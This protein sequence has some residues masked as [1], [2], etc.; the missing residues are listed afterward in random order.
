[1]AV[2]EKGRPTPVTRQ[3]LIR[4][5]MGIGLGLII[6]LAF[7]IT[8]WARRPSPASA[9]GALPTATTIVLGDACPTSITLP[10]WTQKVGVT[11]LTLAQGGVGYFGNGLHE[12]AEWYPQSRWTLY[13][14][15]LSA[16]DVAIDQE[17]LNT[18]PRLP[19]SGR[20]SLHAG[21]KHWVMTAAWRAS[22]CL[23]F[24]APVQSLSEIP[25]LLD[26]V[27]MRR[28]HPGLRVRCTLH[29]TSAGTF[30]GACQITGSAP[31]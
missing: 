17:V 11:T 26:I 31:S 10:A 21:A 19:D 7:L 16:T 8:L 5:A 25:A 27:K 24:S 28:V 13:L 3:S 12:E 22:D 20:V 2:L 30:F 15:G 9:K 29:L 14:G 6:P 18:W 1:M 23:S 4:A